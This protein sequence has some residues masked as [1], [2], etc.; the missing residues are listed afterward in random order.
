MTAPTVR[1]ETSAGNI[2][3][4]FFTDKAPCHVE[5]FLKL[6]RDG[7]YDGTH[8]HRVLPGF[9]IQGGC[10]NTKAGAGGAPGTGGPGWKVDAEFNDVHHERGVLSMARAQDPNS[11]GSQFFVVHGD[12]DRVGFLDRQYTVFGKLVE[13][14]DVLDEIANVDCEF[15]DGRERSRPTE[16]IEIRSAEVFVAE[17]DLLGEDEAAAGEPE[18]AAIDVSK[19]GEGDGA[20][21]AVTADSEEGEEVT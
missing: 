5:N 14:L 7:F 13:G 15:G 16:R 8:F 6:A 21:E 1:L 12:H 10:P 4:E 2:T 20:D 9:M 17:R 19:S 18:A 11:A 3:V